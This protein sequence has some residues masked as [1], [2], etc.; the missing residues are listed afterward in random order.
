MTRKKAFKPGQG[1]TRKDR[2]DVSDNPEWTRASVKA[3]VPFIE[4]FPDLAA[5]IK[6]SRTEVE[7]G[8]KKARR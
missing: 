4:A 5:S 8:L 6:R 2:D 7:L 1:Y 3:S